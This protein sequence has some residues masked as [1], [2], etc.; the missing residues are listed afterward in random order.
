MGTFAAAAAGLSVLLFVGGSLL[1]RGVGRQPPRAPGDLTPIAR[2]PAEFIAPAIAGGLAVALVGFALF[3][4]YRATRHRRPDLPR[5]ALWLLA[6]GAV[7]GGITLIAQRVDIVGV[8][9]DLTALGPGGRQRL[10]GVLRERTT[11]QVILGLNLGAYLALGLSMILV[12]VSAMRAGLLSRLHGF[13]GVAGAVSF[14][15]PF[16]LLQVVL[17]LWLASLVA[18][19][20]DRWPG[21]RGPAWEAGEAKPWPTMAERNAE[22][23]RRRRALDGVDERDG[24]AA[25][26]AGAPGGGEDGGAG[27]DSD[28]VS[29][30]GDGT[31]RTRSRS[32]RKRGRRR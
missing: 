20:L 1:G 12:C 31:P 10:Q 13:L 30:T 15:L 23:E 8:A 22:I 14:V 17:L 19:F 9:R 16:R 7:V 11:L 28:D 18:L 6:F 24:A 32:K 2:Q 5:A 26:G 27:A 4:L 29:A 3:F 21:G 25:A